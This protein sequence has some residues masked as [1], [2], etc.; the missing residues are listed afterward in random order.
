MKLI[1]YKIKV[2]LKRFKILR[3]L[4]DF[5]RHGIFQIT[6]INKVFILYYIYT[7]KSKNF[8][9][10]KNQISKNY[11]GVSPYLHDIELLGKVNERND[12]KKTTAVIFNSSLS[13]FQNKGWEI[14]SHDYVI[15]IN[16]GTGQ[17]KP[18]HLGNK[19]TFRILGKN[20]IYFDKNEILRRTYNKHEYY[21]RL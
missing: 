14:D 16:L 12:T 9:F 13:N 1:F 17:F 7:N 11:P 21:L 18:D 20:W 15:R 19:T 5:L 6:I 10:S 4:N 3:D 8:F 2:F